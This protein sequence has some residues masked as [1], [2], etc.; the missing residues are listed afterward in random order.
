MTALGS[1]LSVS[2]S[3]NKAG[4]QRKVQQDVRFNIEEI[5][6]Q[7]RSSSVNYDFYSKNGSS[8]CALTLG[9]PVACWR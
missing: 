1:F 6:R 2:S 7:S 4:A 8:A 5:A 9:V 3:A